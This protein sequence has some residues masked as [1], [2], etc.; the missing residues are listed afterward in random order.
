VVWAWRTVLHRIGQHALRRGHRI[1]KKEL[2]GDAWNN[3]VLDERRSARA[4]KA[5]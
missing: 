5:A 2:R 4:S 1:H 3:D